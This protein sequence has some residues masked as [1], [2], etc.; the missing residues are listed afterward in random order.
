MWLGAISYSLYLFHTEVGKLM[1]LFLPEAW[2]AAAFVAATAAGSM[3]VAHLVHTLIEK[4][5][6]AAGRKL[7]AR[8]KV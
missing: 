8:L 7:S 3:L 4:P 2:G 1:Y 5:A 6:I